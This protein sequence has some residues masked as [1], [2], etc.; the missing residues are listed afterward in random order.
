MTICD[1]D[2]LVIML[3]SFLGF[4]KTAGRNIVFLSVKFQFGPGT[5]IIL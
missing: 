1:G 2:F 5:V 4:E 3:S